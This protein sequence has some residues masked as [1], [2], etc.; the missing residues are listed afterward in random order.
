[1]KSFYFLLLLTGFTA[2]QT[3]TAQTSTFAVHA[4]IMDAPKTARNVAIGNKSVTACFDQCQT[5]IILNF[6]GQ[7]IIEK[8]GQSPDVYAADVF[9][10]MPGVW[11]AQIEGGQYVNIFAESGA[12]QL[13]IAGQFQVLI[14]APNL[15]VKK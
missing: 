9:Q 12:A 6:C 11:T 14:P 5:Q 15:P 1:M 10:I 2:C 4:E 7:A 8:P 13:D 3:S